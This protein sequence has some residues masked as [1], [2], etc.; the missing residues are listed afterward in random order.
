MKITKVRLPLPAPFTRPRRPPQSLAQCRIFFRPASRA[1]A[2]SLKCRPVRDCHGS[3]IMGEPPRVRDTGAAQSKG[4]GMGFK[5]KW[6]L[7]G[8][9]LA[10]LATTMLALAQRVSDSTDLQFVPEPETLA[11]L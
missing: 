7:R 4:G 8:V 10:M 9:G 5:S 2:K 3:C 11:L 6:A 1:H